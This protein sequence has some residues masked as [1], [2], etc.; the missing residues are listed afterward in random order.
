MPRLLLNLLYLDPGRTGG[1]EVVARQLLP[2]LLPRLAGAW[3]VEAVVCRRAAEQPGP[4]R[5]LPLHVVDVDVARRPAWVAA[6]LGAVPQIARRAR[7]DL[8]HSLGNTTP[9]WSQ[10][11]RSV[12]VHDLIHHRIPHASLASRSARCV[13]GTGAR[14][15]ARI[16]APATQTRDD[17]VELLGIDPQRIDVVHNGVAPT[18]IAPTPVEQLRGRHGLGRRPLVLSP[19]A[20][21]PH[22]NLD[23][24][25]HAFAL[26]PAPRP[27]LV[28]PGYKTGRE[29]ALGTLVQELGIGDD[30]R[31]L[32]WVS[33]ADLEA[34]YAA[35]ELLVFPS[36]Y[37]GF[38]LPVAEA[39][40]RG[41]PV[42]CS[43]RGSLAEVAG[44]A[45]LLFDPDDPAEI[46]TA[47]VRLLDDDALRERLIDAG[48]RQ[49]AR[50]TWPAAADGY[51]HSFARALGR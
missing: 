1:M 49:A 9:L 7:A 43:A 41:L 5:D 38:G 26:V 20:R 45:A 37:E 19:S 24:L 32:G 40:L 17:L 12:T 30:V 14:R 18:T 4:W 22:K 34:L 3:Q 48:C 8:I 13:V 6:E 33:D 11:A 44:D 15:A 35:A 21:Q 36:L 23:R 50:F 25:L 31:F 39:M 29:G 2:E 42:A 27:L 28:L 51:A 46:A 10:A 47:I 16:V